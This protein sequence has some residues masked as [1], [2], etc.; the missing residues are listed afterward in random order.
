M[1]VDNGQNL[2]LVWAYEIDVY[3]NWWNA[4][5][6]TETGNV[7]ALFDWVDQANFNV[8][9]IGVNDPNDGARSNLVDPAYLASSPLGWNDRGQGR[10]STETVGN[11]VY[12]QENWA[13]GSTWQN[14]YRPNPGSSL[15]FNYPINFQTQPD[16]YIDAATTNLFYWGVH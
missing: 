13:G 3:K 15:N 16:A 5:V 9:P 4:M 2:E 8:F 1:Q 11:N 6:S 10:T 7:I 14:N 12:A